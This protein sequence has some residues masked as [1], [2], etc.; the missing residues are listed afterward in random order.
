MS[1]LARKENYQWLEFAS[2]SQLLQPGTLKMMLQRDA[3]CIR[4]FTSGSDD[5]PIG[6]V[7]LSNITQTFKTA[8]LWYALGDKQY[9][10]R[11]CTTRAVHE[12]L[13]LG[14]GT[15]GLRAV[16]AWAVSTNR[17]SIR[18]L[19]HN[20]FQAMGRLRAAHEIDGQVFDRL[21][22]DLLANE[23]KGNSSAQT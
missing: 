5:S 1:W 22:F 17:P 15:L 18:V 4:A 7:A 11:G 2:G 6:V 8:M 19:E 23:Y 20:H 21:L 16:G 14:F 9:A 10:G 3:H 12:I 13:E